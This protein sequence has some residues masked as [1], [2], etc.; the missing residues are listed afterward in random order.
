MATTSNMNEEVHPTAPPQ[1][2][3]APE[4]PRY[5]TVASP[6]GEYP[7]RRRD[8]QFTASLRAAG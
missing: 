8:R 4:P 1:T 6:N 3:M 5:D 2:W 7:M